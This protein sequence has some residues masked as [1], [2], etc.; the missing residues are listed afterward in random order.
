MPTAAR[1]HIPRYPL[2]SATLVGRLAVSEARQGERLGAMLLADAVRRAYA[3]AATVGSSMLVVDAINDRAA[4]FY[5]GNGFVRLQESLR[6]VL[7]MQAIQ[8]LVEP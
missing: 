6:L 1:K 7:P 2:V 8:R 3:S 5:E 4:A